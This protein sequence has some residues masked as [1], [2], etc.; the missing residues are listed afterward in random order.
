M[1]CF[2]K[3]S[4]AQETI[5]EIKGY[6]GWNAEVYRNVYNKKVLAKFQADMKINRN[7]TQTEKIK[8]KEI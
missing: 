8:N 5:T 2:S 6:E 3:E 7:I 1:V 4:E